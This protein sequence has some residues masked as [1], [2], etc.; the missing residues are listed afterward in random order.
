MRARTRRLGGGIGL[1]LLAA[2]RPHPGADTVSLAAEAG[3]VP[4][5]GARPNV[6]PLL[7]PARCRPDQTAFAIEDGGAVDELAIGDA[8]SRG[9]GEAVAMVRRT[10]AG[11]VAGVVLVPRDGSASRVVDLAPT[12]GDAPPPRL[13]SRV[14]DVVAAAYALPRSGAGATTARELKLYSIA[15]DAA[16]ASLGSV[17]EERDD[18]LAFDLAWGENHGVV[19]WDEVATSSRGVVRIAGFSAEPHVGP[20]RDVSPSDS[21]ADSPRVIPHGN[22]FAVL[23]IARSPDPSSAAADSSDLEAIGEPRT[24]GW[25]EMIAVDDQGTPRGPLRRL[26]SPG[27]HVTAFDLLQLGPGPKAVIL[28]VARDD[29]EVVDGSGGALLRVRVTGDVVEPPVAFATDGL[30]RGAPTLVDGIGAVGGGGAQPPSL[31][32]IAS[33][34]H[35]RLL[36]LDLEGAPSAAPS[37]ELAMDDARPLMWLAAGQILVATPLDPSAQLRTFACTR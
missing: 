11:R 4:D 19:V 7:A 14:K 27:G 10:A 2:C 35:L 18:S 34:E 33:H 15:A 36:P 3:D 28:V 25:L 24:H 30:G 12:V 16:V 29:G 20:G 23:W 9:D 31:A 22:G 26:T 1:V 21:D 17:K 6:A 13:V 8:I 32:W 5:E 37:A